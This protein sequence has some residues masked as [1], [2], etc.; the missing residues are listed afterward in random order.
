MDIGCDEDA[1]EDRNLGGSSRPS[2][3]LKS[4]V[5]V[6]EEQIDLGRIGRSQ[7][8]SAMNRCSVTVLNRTHHSAEGRFAESVAGENERVL[9]ERWIGRVCRTPKPSDVLNRNDAY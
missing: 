4:S 6:S 2:P 3:V 8:A 5:A 9:C 1:I 7:G